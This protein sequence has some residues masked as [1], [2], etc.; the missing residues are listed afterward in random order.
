M[1]Y[2]KEKKIGKRKI[3]SLRH[4][5]R[6]KDA[7][8]TEERYLGTE[9][10]KDID[11]Q[12]FDFYLEVISDKLKEIDLIKE[13]IDKDHKKAPSIVLDKENE[14][15]ALLFTYNT[16]KIEGS[17]LTYKESVNLLIHNISPNKPTRDIKETEAHQNLFLE[18]IK[19]EQKITY[20]NL[21]EWHYKLFKDTKPELAGKVRDYKVII[22]G[23]KFVPP[24]PIEVN[25][26]LMD[27][28]KWYLK[29]KDVLHPV[30]LSCLCHLKLVT[31]H[32]FG[33]GNGRITRLIMNVVLNNYNYPLFVI[34]YTDRVDYY[35]SLQGSNLKEDQTIFIKWYINE[36]IKFTKEWYKI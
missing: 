2:I 15:F 17:T 9:I 18:L 8:R 12:K 19:K 5:F 27:F 23:S 31:I 20:Q 21:L 7:Y 29:N 3:Y 32:P 33:D 22:S 6:Y 24:S 13:K 1:V 30:V 25:S 16:N 11:K 36:Y 10:P 14:Q 26:E 4:N 35:N 28:F 34:K